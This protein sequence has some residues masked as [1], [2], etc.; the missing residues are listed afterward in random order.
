VIGLVLSSVGLY[1]VMACAVTGRSQEIGVRLALGAQRRQIRW[2]VL[3]RGVA[4]L[5]VGTT[6]GLAGSLLLRRLLPGGIEGIS[7]HDPI[8]LGGVV[9]LLAVVGVIACLGPAQRATRVDPMVT[10]RE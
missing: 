7:S 4:Q 1:A 6:L 3:R 9:L 8:A 10:L 2:L 5:A